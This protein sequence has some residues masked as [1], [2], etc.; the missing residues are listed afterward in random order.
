MGYVLKSAI[1]A[2]ATRH[3][4]EQTIRPLDNLQT[5]DDEAIVKSDAGE[6]L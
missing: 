5:P 3:R 6:S 1:L 2:F 4:D